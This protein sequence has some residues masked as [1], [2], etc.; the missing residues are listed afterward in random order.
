[1]IRGSSNGRAPKQPKARAGLIG[2]IR[3][4]GFV[5]VVVLLWW[6]LSFGQALP[7]SA[8]QGSADPVVAQSTGHSDQDAALS[9][10]RS[11]VQQGKLTEAERAVQQYLTTHANS[12]DGH[13]LLGSIYFQEVHEQASP[14]GQ[15][16][17]EYS[18][19]GVV[20]SKVKQA[21]AKAS[22]A[23]YTEGAKYRVPSAFELN[24]VAFDYIL[25]GDYADADKWL[26]RAL[27]STPEDTEGWYYLGRTKYNEN[28]FEEAIKAFQRCL[29]TDP[30]S[31]RAQYNLG[32]AY[33]GLGRTEDAAAAFRTAIAW[34]QHKLNQDPEPFIDLGSLMLD[35][36][37]SQD[38]LPYLLRA[39]AISPQEFRAH[40]QLGRAFEH[41]DQLQKAQTEFEKA[42]ALAPQ[43]ARLHYVLGQVYRK[44]GLAEKAKLEFDRSSALR[45]DSPSEGHN[46]SH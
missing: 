42:V 9:Q 8:R 18:N 5:P 17:L 13:Y 14:Q 12:A 24:V 3:P 15:A 40:E 37:Q 16:E 45:R 25:L 34:Q 41:L 38:A 33:Q 20:D 1:V 2:T 10:A 6:S 28:R 30:A 26:T 39:V 36:N 44:E 32:L 43:N 46:E 27:Q 29:K 22:L 23:E 11:L 19:P 4:G 31:L 35:E 21:K 7:P